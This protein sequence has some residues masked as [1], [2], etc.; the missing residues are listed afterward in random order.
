MTSNLW[1]LIEPSILLHTNRTAWICR[2]QDGRRVVGYRQIYQ[3]ALATAGR[4]RDQEIGPGA[5]IGIT[6]P[7]GP[8]WTIA[9][10]AAWRLGC[11]IAPIHIGNSNHEIAAQID[12]VR[13]DVMM[14]HDSDLIHDARM[15]ISLAEDPER[16]AR[17]KSL[18]AANDPHAVA[19]RLYTSGSTGNPK[20]VRLSHSNLAT[21]VQAAMKVVPFG[22]EDRFLSLLPFSHAMGITGNVNLAYFVGATLIS[23]RVLGAS[24]IIASLQEEHIS[25]VIAVPRLFR[26]VMLGLDKK[27]SEGGRGMALYRQLLKASPPKL[28]M[29]LNAPVRKKLG[30]KI[31]VWVSGGSRLDGRITRFY[32]E[33]GL[34]LRQGYG[35]TETSPL[36]CVQDAFDDAP[37]SV[38]KPVDQVQ[39]RVNRPDEKGQGEIWIKGPNIM[40][41][42]ENEEQDAA[43]FEDGWFKT[44]DLGRLDDQGRVTLTGRIKRLI[45]TEAGKNVYP[46]ELE[47]LLERNPVV[48]EA[49][50]FELDSRPACVLAMEGDKVEETA[51]H[52]ITD[53]NALVSSHNRIVRYAVVDELPR[54]PLGKVALQKLA[55]VFGSHEVSKSGQ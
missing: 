54:T 1:K 3:A 8:E 10:L 31:K 47:S 24:E 27:F 4:L 53:F 40:L 7:N 18:A 13:P 11:M 21:N 51:R 23:P 6:A 42:Y 22:P 38:G 39:V 12:A 9:A 32:H 46:E 30:G 20:V 55:A 41:G 34:P 44:G 16:V 14:V 19:A 28:R 37:E 49:G 35:L 33:L 43:V 52:V 2:E 5:T 36:A 50:V 48:K 15:E 29:Y 17:E 25:V 26:N 45:V